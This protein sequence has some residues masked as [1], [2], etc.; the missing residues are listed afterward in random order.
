MKK[1]KAIGKSTSKSPQLNFNKS[2]NRVCTEVQFFGSNIQRGDSL[3]NLNAKRT[4]SQKQIGIAKKGW[5]PNT[6]GVWMHYRKCFFWKLF[7]LRVNIDEYNTFDLSLDLFDLFTCGNANDVITLVLGRITP[8][9]FPPKK[10]VLVSTNLHVQSRRA[11]PQDSR[12]HII[13]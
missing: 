9:N 6:R 7:L 4:T 1:L 11:L 5:K 8:K 12:Y 3:H 13:W 10:K 2:P